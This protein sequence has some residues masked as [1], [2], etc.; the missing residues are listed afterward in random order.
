MSGDRDSLIQQTL[1]DGSTITVEPLN[2]LHRTSYISRHIDGRLVWG[3]VFGSHNADSHAQQ[4]ADVIA[5]ATLDPSSLHRWW[6][7][8]TSPRHMV[9]SLADGG[10]RCVDCG[11]T[12]DRWPADSEPCGGGRRGA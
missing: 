11:E 9:R 12:F 6:Y 7:T 2:D 10:W 8:S 3:Q 1:S 4:I 5:G